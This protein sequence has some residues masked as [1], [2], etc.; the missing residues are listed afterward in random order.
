MPVSSHML[1]IQPVPAKSLVSSFDNKPIV[2][3]CGSLPQTPMTWNVLQSVNV[4]Q[5]T[6]I[7]C[8]NVLTYM[9][10]NCPISFV[11]LELSFLLLN[12]KK[13]TI[14]EVKLLKT[15]N[16]LIQWWHILWLTGGCAY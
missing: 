11:G 15:N 16:M 1:N 2:H 9:S 8:H 10:D 14:T 13:I 12:W 3:V 6:S 5:R 4:A 7:K